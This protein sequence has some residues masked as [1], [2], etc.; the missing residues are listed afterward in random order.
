MLGG[1]LE[2]IK[3]IYSHP[4][5]LSQC[6][7]YLEA[8]PEWKH[9]E[10]ASTATAA[11]MVSKLDSQENA[12]IASPV[13]ASL[14]KLETLCEDIED[15]PGNF[16]RFVVIKANNSETKYK[17][18]NVAP[19]T[20]SVIFKTKNEPGALYHCLGVIDKF[21]L[22]LSRL[23]SRPIQGEPWKYW[24]YADIDLSANAET[25]TEKEVKAHVD[26]AIET[27]K[28][29]AEDVRVLGIY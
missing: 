16:T 15:N 9:I 4:Q 27:L 8:Y 12:A 26:S 5:A 25:H 17:N 7:K 24:F 18:S 11:M 2:N 22:N 19:K 10:A 1:S 21:N 13:N 29:T 3:N 23:E 14:Y 6:K 28:H 20:A